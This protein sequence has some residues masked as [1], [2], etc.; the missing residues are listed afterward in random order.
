MQESYRYEDTVVVMFTQTRE[1]V[2]EFTEKT[3]LKTA[4]KEYNDSY[5]ESL[6]KANQCPTPRHRDDA[7]KFVEKGIMK[8]KSF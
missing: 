1:M 8:S 5:K 2:R 3:N 7:K 6:D 4:I